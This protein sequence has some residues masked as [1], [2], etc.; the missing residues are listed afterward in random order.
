MHNFIEFD[1]LILLRVLAEVIDE[2][3][4]FGGELVGV[5]VELV[6]GEEFA[7]GAF[8]ALDAGDDAVE[9]LRS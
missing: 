1:R 4:A 9:P 5:G 8:A 7:D 6:V 2:F 3:D